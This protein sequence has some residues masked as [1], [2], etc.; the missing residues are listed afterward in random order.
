[1]PIDK[2]VPLPP[3]LGIKA[4]PEWDEAEIG[5]SFAV[6]CEKYDANEVAKAMEATARLKWGAWVSH[7]TPAGL[8]SSVR[9]W[10]V[11]KGKKYGLCPGDTMPPRIKNTVRKGASTIAIIAN[12]MRM[13][14][15]EDR[16]AIEKCIADMVA[17]GD[18]VAC[19][20]DRVYRGAPVIEYGLPKTELTA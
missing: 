20:T 3:A 11:E 8:R 13:R 12:K 17:A 4:M 19:E 16:A 9:I 6:E 5:D 18:M 14:S 15:D 1:M 10:R 7:I 2:N